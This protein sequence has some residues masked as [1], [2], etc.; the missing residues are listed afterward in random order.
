M[1]ASSSSRTIKT[2]SERKGDEGLAPKL[3]CMDRA[4]HSSKPMPAFPF[5][6][7]DPHSGRQLFEHLVFMSKDDKFFAL[8][9]DT[10]AAANLTGDKYLLRFEE[11][12][13]IPFG[14]KIIKRAGQGSFSGISGQT[15]RCTEIWWIPIYPGHDGGE[16]E[17][18][19]HVIEH[20][21][22]PPLLSSESMQKQGCMIDLRGCRIMVPIETEPGAYQVWPLKYDGYHFKWPIMYTN[23]DGKGIFC[24]LGMIDTTQTPVPK[25]LTN[26]PFPRKDEDEEVKPVKTV[27]VDEKWEEANS[28]HKVTSKPS[29]ATPSTKKSAEYIM[30]GESDS[31][32]EETLTKAIMFGTPLP[33]L[34]GEQ[35]TKLREKLRVRNKRRPTGP[36][37]ELTDEQ[38]HHTRWDMWEW[39]GGSG[40]LTK[41]CD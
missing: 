16:L 22:L 2:N 23:D 29:R 13:L 17:Y 5:W 33:K 35:Q 36:P 34:T 37:P 15:M 31:D 26:N 21:E 19:A 38:R 12:I 32:I 8:Y 6:K 28:S 10:G 3:L 18:E 41:A 20:S 9:L 14:K 24:Q 11:V 27:T 25:A 7:H 30:E 1:A 4:K 39:F 40:V